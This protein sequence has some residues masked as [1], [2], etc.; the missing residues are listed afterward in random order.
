MNVAVGG[1]VAA[2]MLAGTAAVLTSTSPPTQSDNHDIATEPPSPTKTVRYD[3][4]APLPG[5][6]TAINLSEPVE[7][8]AT[9]TSSVNL[10]PRPEGATAVDVSVVCLTAGRIVYPDGASMVCGGPA[11]EAAIADPRSTNYTLI[12]L[13]EG[14]TSITF[15][16][17]ENVQWKVVTKYVRT[18]T[19]DWGTN[20]KGETFGVERDGKSPDLIAVYTT[21][22]KQ[23]YAYTKNL[24][25]RWPVPTSPADALAQQEA[26][27]G[28]TLSVPVYQSD[29]ETLIGEFIS[30]P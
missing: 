26:N 2:A 24:D 9:G 3:N 22:G 8:T 18:R 23:G 11:D 20:A 1:A 15:R 29:G 14:Q 17:K 13:A 25:G 28:N 4:A 16:A 12:D 10:G 5:E 6:T 30:G 27:E 21:D 19:S 7:V